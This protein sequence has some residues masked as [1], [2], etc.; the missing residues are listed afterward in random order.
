M[1][2]GAQLLGAATRTLRDAGV[3]DPV[4]DARVLLAHV[5]GVDR[6]R[7]TVVLPDKIADHEAA[8]YERAIAARAKRQPVAQITG[9]RAFYGRDF[10]VTGDVLDPRPDTE[11]LIDT[12]LSASFD[13]L[14]DLGTGTGCI[15][16]TLL[17]ERPEAQ[18]Q[19]VDLSADAL[20]IARSNAQVLQVADRAEFTEGSWFE[21]VDADKR[22]DLIVCN[23]P[24]ISDDEMATLAPEVRDWEPHLALTPG[25]DGLAAYRQIISEAPQHLV[26]GGRLIVEIG[27]GQGAAVRNLFQRAGFVAIQLLKDLSQHDRVVIGNWTSTRNLSS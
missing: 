19:G 13:T 8:A 20:S 5:L 24:Y 21:M 16:L 18:G 23:P 9:T 26:P 10:I 25:G 27:A 22:F 17:A 14:L 12:A 3:D 6:S 11:L 15:L 4:R 7:L 1:T 2:S